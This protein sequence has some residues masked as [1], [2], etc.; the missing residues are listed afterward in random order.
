M[1]FINSRGAGTIETNNPAIIA[2]LRRLRRNLAAG[3]KIRGSDKQNVA[4]QFQK[5]SEE[6]PW[7]ASRRSF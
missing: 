1:E 4:S 5:R 7:K 6:K 2:I 3:R